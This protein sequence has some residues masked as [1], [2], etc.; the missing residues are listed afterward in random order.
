[1]YEELARWWSEGRAQG[2]GPRLWA[3]PIDHVGPAA[4]EHEHPPTAE[5][6]DVSSDVNDRSNID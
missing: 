1:M 2:R 3:W 4:E 5:M 6:A